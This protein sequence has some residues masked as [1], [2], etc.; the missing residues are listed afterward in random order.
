MAD[1][2]VNP[3]QGSNPL[4]QPLPQPEAD[5]QNDWVKEASQSPATIWGLSLWL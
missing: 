4:P 2:I 1:F 3:V 5:D